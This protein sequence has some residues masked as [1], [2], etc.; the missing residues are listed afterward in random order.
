MFDVS[1]DLPPPPHLPDVVDWLLL[2]AM[3]GKSRDLDY[4]CLA[5]LSLHK[6]SDLHD[7]IDCRLFLAKSSESFD[8]DCH[9]MAFFFPAIF[10]ESHDLHA[11]YWSVIF[12]G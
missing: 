5:P 4:H 2:L 12:S 6:L 9:R 3:F 8:L 7:F 11:F 10:G 1:F